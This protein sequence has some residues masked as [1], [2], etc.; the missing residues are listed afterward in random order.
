MTLVSFFSVTPGGV[1]SRFGTSL[2]V[3]FL[4]GDFLRGLLLG[5]DFLPGGDLLWDRDLDLLLGD[6]DLV[7]DWR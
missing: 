7:T 5:G 1:G 6:L 2:G 4:T 3:G